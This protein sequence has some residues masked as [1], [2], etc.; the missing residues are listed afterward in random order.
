MCIN[1]KVK[2]LLILKNPSTQSGANVI[3]FPT[4]IESIFELDWITV[5]TL[6]SFGSFH[7]V[8]ITN[9]W[10]KLMNQFLFYKEKL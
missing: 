3:L 9:C 8:S 2:L 7:K 4:H 10:S 1:I 6:E 5:S